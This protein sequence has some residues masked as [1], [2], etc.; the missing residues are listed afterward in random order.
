MSLAKQLMEQHQ[1]DANGAVNA[2]VASEDLSLSHDV[3]SQNASTNTNGHMVDTT[4]ESSSL[5]NNDPSLVSAAP[6]TSTASSL[7]EKSTRKQKKDFDISSLEAFPS[8]AN[9]PAATSAAPSWGTAP[10]QAPSSPSG[11]ISKNVSETYTVPQS[12]QNPGVNIS[13][14]VARVRKLTGTAIDSST[15]LRTKSTSFVIRGLPDQVARAKRELFRAVGRKVRRSI[16]IPASARSAVIG[17]KGSRIEPIVVQSAC[18]IDV[19]KSKSTGSFR[20]KDEFDEE[21]VEVTIEGESSGVQYAIDQINAIVDSVVTEVNVR[22]RDGVVP[23]M[24][25]FV[26]SYAQSSCPQVKVQV[27]TNGEGVASVVIRGGRSDVQ[28]VVPRIQAL[29]SKLQAEYQTKSI[30]LPRQRL[31]FVNHDAVFEKA[32][33]VVLPASSSGESNELTVYGSQDAL[34]KCDR[35]IDEMT[36]NTQNLLLDIGKA[37]GKNLSHAQSLIKYFNAKKSTNR[38]QDVNGVV[39]EALPE[40][41]TYEIIGSDQA[42]ILSAKKALVEL[43]NE[44]PPSR[45]RVV[46]NIGNIM[47][48]LV[49]DIKSKIVDVVLYDDTAIAVYR[50]TASDEDDDFGP[51][52]DEVRQSLDDVEAQLQK[53]ADA[54][55]ALVDT[56]VTISPQDVQYVSSALKQ[57]RRDVSG[58][59]VVVLTF[60]DKSNVVTVKALADKA[61]DLAAQVETAIADAKTLEQ[62]SSY[63]TQFTFPSAHVNKLIGKQG[64]NLNKLCEEFDVKIDVEGNSGNGTIQGLKKNADAAKHKIL[65]LAQRLADEVTVKIDVPNEYHAQL[66]GPGGKFVKRLM[67]RYDVFIQI[68]KA[69]GVPPSPIAGSTPASRESTPSVGDDLILI[70]GPSKGVEKTKGEIEELVK[71]IRDSN[72]Q[73][74]I[75][76]PQSALRRII[77]RQGEM[78]TTIKNDT[79]TRIDIHHEDESVKDKVSIDIS[80]NKSGVK[81]AVIAVQEI[82]KDVLDRTEQTVSI[83][84]QYHRLII[85][86]QGS[87]K[88]DIITQCGGDSECSI[89]VPS[90]DKKD[91]NIR[92]AGTRKAVA[93]AVKK[94]EDIVAQ[95]QNQVEEIVKDIES[96]RYGALIGSGGLVKRDIE[97]RFNVQLYVPKRG[98]QD[99]VKISG[100]NQAAVDAAKQEVLSIVSSGD[101][102]A[103]VQVEVPRRLHAELSN[104]GAFVRQ[105][106]SEFSVKIDFGKGS[107]PKNFSIPAAP[108]SFVG[109]AM[110]VSKKVSEQQF[111]FHFMEETEPPAAESNDTDKN[112]VVVWSI[113]G[114]DN[115]ACSK[116]AKVVQNSLDQILKHDSVGYLWLSRPKLY[117]RIVG[118]QGSRINKIRQD[119]GASILVPASDAVDAYVSMR[120]NHAQLELAKDLILKAVN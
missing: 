54:Q 5:L 77:G 111:A 56:T 64:A 105:V 98:S 114:A 69:A 10:L 112:K 79:D 71:Y 48:K 46:N 88:R 93:K 80:G 78:V 115:D 95:Q 35:L 19:K 120:G 83:D 21:D 25:K 75:T 9:G 58:K 13:A 118:P 94:I 100:P 20:N 68:P 4:T 18:S 59:D 1:I 108:Q 53:L 106:E 81:R 113:S 2:G 72:Y 47:S 28:Q 60:D 45:L 107:V 104:K 97:T 49:A 17:P 11:S 85:G 27:R 91:P 41:T 82:V 101:S 43:V 84:L 23:H 40:S 14:E 31:R 66:I 15:S 110:T 24:A 73:E 6:A 26:E 38:I 52:D 62:L 12:E 86:P 29:I 42:S 96:D 32:H 33:V 117:G 57:V 87:T 70:R 109:E 89:F 22:I 116:A 7:Q 50:N 103:R 3:Q 119:S 99:N 90:S 36:K 67:D 44:I 92:V 16:Y 74:T 30:P 76:V 61:A 63:T 102:A 39:I 51:S 65:N 8:L 55:A 37:H 34:R